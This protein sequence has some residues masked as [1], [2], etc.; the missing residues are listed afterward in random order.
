MVMSVSQ[1]GL[2][3]QGHRR[4][5][6]AALLVLQQVDTGGLAQAL[7]QLAGLLHQHI[8]G[9]NRQVE[10]QQLVAPDSLGWVALAVIPQEL[11]GGER[12]KEDRIHEGDMAMRSPHWTLAP[13]WKGL[14]CSLL[15]PHF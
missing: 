10:G 7:G 12:G 2:E 6:G 5:H 9:H 3:N 11:P 1:V 14:P 4:M 8:R 13:G 15:T